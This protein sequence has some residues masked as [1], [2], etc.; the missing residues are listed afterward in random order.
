MKKEDGRPCSPS[1]SHTLLARSAIT[2]SSSTTTTA[3]RN[4]PFVAVAFE[5]APQSQNEGMG[6]VDCAAP[7]CEIDRRLE[8]ARKPHTA[9][10][11][12]ASE[13]ASER[14]PARTPVA[15]NCCLQG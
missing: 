8:N 14:A 3:G 10:H 12:R 4:S 13:R 2:S 1:L 7:G 6:F 15:S 5:N 11:T 9:K